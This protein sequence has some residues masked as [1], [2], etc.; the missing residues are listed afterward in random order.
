MRGP[1]PLSL[2]ATL[3]RPHW[4]KKNIALPATLCLVQPLQWHPLVLGVCICVLLQ[5]FRYS[6][7][8]N[9]GQSG[10]RSDAFPGQ[11]STNANRPASTATGLPRSVDGSCSSCSV[12]PIAIGVQGVGPW[13]R[14]SNNTEIRQYDGSFSDF[15]YDGSTNGSTIQYVPN[16]SRPQSINGGAPLSITVSPTLGCI[17][18]TVLCHRAAVH[19]GVS[20]CTEP[21][22]QMHRSH[23]CELPE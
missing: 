12:V 5:P 18:R 9:S 21:P 16:D 22:S 19:L 17:R 23:S 14:Q 11:R 10:V 13:R 3:V 7:R 8:A 1:R 15:A 6:R 4:Q 20:F 2:R